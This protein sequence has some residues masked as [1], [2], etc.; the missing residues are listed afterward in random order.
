MPFGFGFDFD[1]DHHLDG[2]ASVGAIGLHDDRLYRV[3]HPSALLL[4]HHD[5]D[6]GTAHGARLYAGEER[7]VVGVRHKDTA[8]QGSERGD[9]AVGDQHLEAAA[10][11]GRILAPE[12]CAP[13]GFYHN[14]LERVHHRNDEVA[15]DHPTKT[16]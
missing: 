10:G 12:A 16:G 2:P 6:E 4:R 13:W 11:C 7:E 15:P 14:R 5:R 8:E 9:M 3:H 1:L